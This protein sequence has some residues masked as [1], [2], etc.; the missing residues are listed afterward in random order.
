MGKLNIN[1]NLSEG[2]I[3]DYEYL[4]Y[5]SD[6]DAIGTTVTTAKI[7]SSTQIDPITKVR[8]KFSS[9]QYLNFELLVN[10][11]TVRDTKLVPRNRFTDHSYIVILSYVDSANV[12]RWVE[13]TFND[14]TSFYMIGSSNIAD[15]TN[16]VITGLKAKL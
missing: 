16:V 14:D 9:Y 3:V 4:S 13:V 5:S 15:N 7:L 10:N 11:K 6:E 12:Q 2:L 1:S 8:R